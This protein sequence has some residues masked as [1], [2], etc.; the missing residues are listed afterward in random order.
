M[1]F[2]KT[3]EPMVGDSVNSEDP[4]NLYVFLKKQNLVYSGTTLD[5]N[6][7]QLPI[8]FFNED[9]IDLFREGAR[10][11]FLVNNGNSYNVLTPEQ[12]KAENEEMVSIYIEDLFSRYHSSYSILPILESFDSISRKYGHSFVTSEQI[13]YVRER[14]KNLE[15]LERLPK[16]CNE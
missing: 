2:V 16:N 14:I 9:E 13:K 8:G 1:A 5:I 11:L 12:Q 3:I 4:I 15:K 6:G 7:D 10:I